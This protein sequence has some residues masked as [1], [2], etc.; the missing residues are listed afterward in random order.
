[1]KK[2]VFALSLLLSLQSH[3]G[4]TSEDIQQYV[5]DILN[6]HYLK[7]MALRDRES[8]GQFSIRE[9]LKEAPTVRFFTSNRPFVQGSGGRRDCAIHFVRERKVEFSPLCWHQM[10]KDKQPLLI[11]HETLGALGFDDEEYQISLALDWYV[12]NPD[13]DAGFDF[14]IRRSQREKTYQRVAGGT[15]LV[16]GGGSECELFVKSA[17]VDAALEAGA[18]YVQHALRSVVICDHFPTEGMTISEVPGKEKFSPYR[19]LWKNGRVEVHTVLILGFDLGSGLP[20]LK[21][22]IG[23]EFK[24]FIDQKKN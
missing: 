2:I 11:L 1:M 4:S 13:R 17:I 16:G 6:T 3:A 5:S 20:W 21:S 9:F 18:P 10:R 7:P 15:S 23:R 14:P 19:Q 24:S 12:R 22:F 8:F